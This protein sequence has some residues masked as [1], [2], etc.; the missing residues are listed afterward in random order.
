M[1]IIFNCMLALPTLVEWLQGER[2]VQR[3]AV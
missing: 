1:G 2:E 3:T